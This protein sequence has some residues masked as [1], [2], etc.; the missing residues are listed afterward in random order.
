VVGSES[1]DVFRLLA[2]TQQVKDSLR[3][4]RAILPCYS[5]S[6]LK[7]VIWR[8]HNH[9]SDAEVVGGRHARLLCK[10]VLTDVLMARRAVGY[11]RACL[12]YGWR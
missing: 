12:S 7:H 11:A 6:L 1:A 5:I 4:D 10:L 8:N 2:G 3:H 9:S